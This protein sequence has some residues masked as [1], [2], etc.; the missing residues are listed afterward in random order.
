M[1]DFRR[2]IAA[3]GMAIC[4]LAGF[5]SVA[6]AAGM[7]VSAVLAPQEQM[8]LNFEDGSK[9]FVLMV[10]REGKADGSGPLSGASVTEYGMHDIT[11]GVAGDPHGFLRFAAANGDKAYIKWV[12]RAIFVPNPGGKKKFKLLDYGH[13]EV[14]GGTGQY[15]GMK[16]VGT[17][18]IKPASK[19]DRRFTLEGDLFPAK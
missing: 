9:R 1:W 2:N 17:M 15:A 3:G 18:T 4:L 5:G 16:G 8:R 12:V 19:T 10:R 6:S 14:V 13:W 7:K 11:P